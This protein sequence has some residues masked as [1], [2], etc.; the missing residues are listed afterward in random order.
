[1]E[2]VDKNGTH[3]YTIVIKNVELTVGCM[4]ETQ[5]GNFLWEMCTTNVN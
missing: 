1:M 2:N 4:H 3:T 5:E